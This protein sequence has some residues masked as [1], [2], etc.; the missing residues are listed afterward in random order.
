M[1]AAR[2][3]GRST[4]WWAWTWPCGFL[5][6]ILP[7]YGSTMVSA[8]TCFVRSASHLPSP[9][10]SQVSTNSNALILWCQQNS[11][12]NNLAKFAKADRTFLKIEFLCF[13]QAATTLFASTR[14]RAFGWRRCWRATTCCGWAPAPGSSSPSPSPTSLWPPANCPPSQL[15]SVSQNMT[16]CKV[17][18]NI[19]TLAR[20]AFQKL[21]IY[22]IYSLLEF[23]Y[24]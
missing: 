19:Y 4:A 8:W 7:A 5:C 16:V 11:P 3:I 23:Y 1:W 17:I 6:T 20:L 13:Q 18:K 2:A 24:F 9:K 14:R 22:S 10:C 21:N 12:K 15:W